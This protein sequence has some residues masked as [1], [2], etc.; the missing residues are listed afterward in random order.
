[1]TSFQIPF[2][3]DALADHPV[4]GPHP[5]LEWTM[6]LQHLAR[7]L[8]GEIKGDQVLAPGP[9]HSRRDRSMSVRLDP[10]APD[11]FVVPS[12][13]PIK[14]K[15]YIRERAGF[16]AFKPKRKP[17]FN[18]SKFL[19]A[20]K[21]A[22][23]VSEPVAIYDYRDDSGEL[24]Y[25]VLRYE[26]KAF[27]Q[28]R[29][30]GNGGWIWNLD[31]V[32]RVPYRW[33]DL[34][35]YP[36]ATVFVCEGEKD[37][38]RVASLDHCTTTVAGGKWTADC[39]EPLAG[40]DVLI[41]EDADEPG[42]KKAIAA[43]TALHGQAKTIRIVRLPGL[44]GHPN[45]KDVSD[46]LDADPRRANKLADVCFD[47]PLWMS[48]AAASST[49]GD[50]VRSPEF[51]RDTTN[52]KVAVATTPPALQFARMDE[53]E[54]KHVEW[55]WNGRLARGKLTLL[56]GEPGI[57]KSQT[58]LDIAARISV[59]GHWPDGGH[60][61]LGSVII[62]SAEDSANDTLRPRLEAANA[63][64][65]RIHALQATVVEGK[66]VTFSLQAHLEMLGNKLTEIGD[67]ALI[68]IDPITS[69]MGKI[70]G[71]QTVDVRTVLEPLAAFAEKHDVAVLAISHPPKATQSKALHAVTGS[72]AFV[73][74]ARV[75]LLATK[76]PQTER[77]LLLPVKNNLGPP[78]PGLGFSLAQCF[79]GNEILTSHVIWDSAPVTTTADEAVAASNHEGAT[80]MREAADFL[81]EELASDPR[82]VR[83]L[84]QAAADAGLSWATV[85][86]A[87]KDLGI[88]P[89]KDGLNGG[90]LWQLPR[91]TEG[92]QGAHEDAHS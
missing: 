55:V 7:T 58:S 31:G 87:Q 6:D 33:P 88:K 79:I 36:D 1:M 60:A 44:T 43:A 24:V 71:H 48:H 91:A 86:R 34:L 66:P 85:R 37:A 16:E 11:G 51:L 40:R 57:G 69:Y 84:K 4:G 19:A 28:R 76:E 81:R 46:W 39:V 45:N 30:D 14:C 62:L 47:A 83:D 20:Q 59:G 67:T 82:S 2:R 8:D 10:A 65:E 54:A 90:W 63:D 49:S 17:A 89:Q 78:A 80:A 25:Q 74:A 9:G 18:I 68:I 50:R 15:D 77:R 12:D 92:A 42:H 21:N 53:V 41:L 75:V 64:L 29:P 38:D 5:F 61:P 32:R 73:A 22:D 72:L 56:A 3:F 23:P 13:D 27:R 70:D 35:Q 52:T 26:P